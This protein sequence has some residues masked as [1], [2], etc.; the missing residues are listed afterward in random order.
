MIIKWKKYF[1]IHFTS[2]TPPVSQ[3]QYHCL[4]LKLLRMTLLT[5]QLICVFPTF[6]CYYKHI[7]SCACHTWTLFT[8]LLVYCYEKCLHVPR[9][10]LEKCEAIETKSVL[11]ISDTLHVLKHGI[12]IH[13][14]FIS[15][16]NAHPE[17]EHF[18]CIQFWN[19][20]WFQSHLVNYCA[21]VW[22]VVWIY[23]RGSTG[24]MSMLELYF[25]PETA[26]P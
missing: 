10:N 1:K 6:F 26:K 12:W 13:H 9:N 21:T 3:S 20:A 5:Q 18:Y 24:R 19:P 16:G 15:T 7:L 8:V 23:D 4:L 22:P 2:P 25:F 11:K 17:R 14:Q